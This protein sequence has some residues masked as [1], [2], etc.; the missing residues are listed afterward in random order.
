[1]SYLPKFDITVNV[2]SG[3]DSVTVG[4]RIQ[5][6]INYEVIAKSEEDTQIRIKFMSLKDNKRVRS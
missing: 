4:D 6:T 3:L 5:G 1:M 2:V